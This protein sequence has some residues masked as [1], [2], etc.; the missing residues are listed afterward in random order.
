MRIRGCASRTRSSRPPSNATRR[1]LPNKRA[2]RK[3]RVEARRW[4]RTAMPP[5]TEAAAGQDSASRRC[6]RHC[7]ARAFNLRANSSAWPQ[8]SADNTRRAGPQARPAVALPGCRRAYFAAGSTFE[9]IQAPGRGALPIHHADSRSADCLRA[10]LRRGF[11]L[12]ANSSAW[13]GA[14][15]MRAPALAPPNGPPPP[16]SRRVF[17][18]RSN[19]NCWQPGSRLFRDALEA[20]ERVARRPFVVML[21]L[22]FCEPKR[23]R[24]GARGAEFAA[25]GSV[26]AILCSEPVGSRR[27]RSAAVARAAPYRC[28]PVALRARVSVFCATSRARSAPCL[29]RRSISL[30]SARSAS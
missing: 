12:R 22:N 9:Q 15:P 5:N 2:E 8:R 29:S 19:S 13:T 17:D 27:R 20:R 25:W 1:A 24:G 10:L 30:L 14:L 11:N 21:G 16:P 23:A 28:M 18:L 26:L 6:A 3:P 4:A 7:R